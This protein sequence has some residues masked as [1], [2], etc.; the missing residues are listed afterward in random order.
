MSVLVSVSHPVAGMRSQSPKPALHVIAH[1]PPAHALDALARTSQTAPHIPQ[2]ALLVLVSTHA[3][4]QLL[5]PIAQPLAHIPVIASQ[6]GV[7]PEHTRPHV[8]QLDGEESE[9][10]QPF[11]ALPSQSAKPAAH[12]SAQRP[13]AHDAR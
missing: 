1:E 11:A 6:L 3:P 12:E 4:E 8:P 10:S 13:P 9:A 2:C 5:W 7:A